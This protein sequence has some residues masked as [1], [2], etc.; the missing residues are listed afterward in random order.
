[1]AQNASTVAS[2]AAAPGFVDAVVAAALMDGADA[3]SVRTAAD[4]HIDDNDGKWQLAKHCMLCGAEMLRLAE[5]DEGA[6]KTEV[7]NGK[8]V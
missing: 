5:H 3:E 4:A 7:E 6:G 8:T 2:A 1:M